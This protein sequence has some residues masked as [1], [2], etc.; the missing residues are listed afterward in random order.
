MGY[1]ELDVLDNSPKKIVIG[2]DLG[3]TNSLPAMWVDDRP[4][5]SVVPPSASG[6]AVLRFA[7]AA[8]APVER[9]DVVR[10]GQVVDSL[11]GQGR[12]DWSGRL[13]LPALVAGEYVYVRVV[14][15]DG[16]AAWASPVYVDP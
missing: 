6:S 14:Q 11:A 4:M 16:G 9:V 2:I 7:V 10:S 13:E 8:T 15:T 12:T 3:T 5:G 1:I